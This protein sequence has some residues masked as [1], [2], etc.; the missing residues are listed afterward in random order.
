MGLTNRLIILV[1]CILVILSTGATAILISPSNIH[2]SYEPGKQHEFSIS[3]S[4]TDY[5][6]AYIDGELAPYAELIS[7][8]QGKAPMNIIVKFTQPEGLLPGRHKLFV[9]AIEALPQ[10]QEIQVGIR[11][12]A[13]VQAVIYVDVPY[14][15]V[16]IEATIKAQDINIG[17]KEKFVVS[18]ANKGLE[19]VS[20]VS[21]R[22]KVLDIDNN[23]VAELASS[24][25]KPLGNLSSTDFEFEWDSAAAGANPGIY[26]A[27]ANVNYD[28]SIV[29]TKEAKFKI[30][31]LSVG[32]T[33]YTKEFEAGTISPFFI[34][35][36]SG[37]NEMLQGVYGELI[38]GGKSF[39]TLTS[40]LNPWQRMKL[41]GYLDSNG[42]AEGGYDAKFIVHYAGKTT[43]KSDKLLITKGVGPAREMP[44][45]TGKTLTAGTIT[46]IV[47]GVVLVAAIV[48]LVLVYLANRKN[49]IYS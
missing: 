33:D 43:E 41:N 39:K 6:E 11:A 13:S 18:V 14:P 7:P 47:L 29:T 46:M 28:G 17:E 32:I 10:T 45:G 8:V 2:L 23:T 44:A 36:E 16:Y 15:G 49:R 48:L 40:D 22:V 20:R 3:V 38:V 5:L 37:W 9:G 26:R 1:L 25:E 19:A 24:E 12:R 42:I 4:E 35:I 27:V 31:S 21:A 30:G 34:E